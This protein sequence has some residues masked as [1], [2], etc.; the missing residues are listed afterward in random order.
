MFTFRVFVNTDAV[1]DK[2]NVSAERVKRWFGLENVEQRKR[3][4]KAEVEKEEEGV[5]VSRGDAQESELLGRGRSKRPL[6]W[7]VNPQSPRV[8]QRPPSAQIKA[9]V[10]AKLPSVIGPCNAPMREKIDFET[11]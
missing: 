3:K 11:R 10:A 8:R 5:L 2:K 9:S 7:D 4:R 1:P 6:K